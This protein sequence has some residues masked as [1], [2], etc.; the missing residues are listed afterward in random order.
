M[1]LGVV[2][3]GMELPF[4]LSVI[5]TVSGF[6]AETLLGWIWLAM[7]LILSISK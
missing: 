3:G 6:L 5:E 7:R 2:I 4:L 1:D